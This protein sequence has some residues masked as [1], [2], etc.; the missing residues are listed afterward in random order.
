MFQKKCLHIP[1]YLH[2]RNSFDTFMF[3]FLFFDIYFAREKSKM[4]FFFSSFFTKYSIFFR[5]YKEKPFYFKSFTCIFFNHMITKFKL[6][7]NKI[8]EK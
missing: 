5:N 6:Y 7:Y 3:L 8:Y 2:F 1:I 4:S